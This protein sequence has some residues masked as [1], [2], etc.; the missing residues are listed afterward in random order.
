MTYLTW[1]TYD[2]LDVV[3]GELLDDLAVDL[4]LQRLGL[5]RALE[6]LVGELVDGACP[7]GRVVAHVLHHRWGHR[8]G[9]QQCD[10]FTHLI[11]LYCCSLFSHLLIVYSELTFQVNFL[12]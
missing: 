8:Q 4:V 9:L 3:V 6:Y 1:L 7:F 5:Q 12:N 10:G 2:L 11:F